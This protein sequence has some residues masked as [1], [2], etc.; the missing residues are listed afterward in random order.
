M[1]KYL[2]NTAELTAVADAIRTKGGTEELLTYPAGFVT[3]IEN[4]STGSN[5]DLPFAN[6][7]GTLEPINSL[8][9]VISTVESMF[10]FSGQLGG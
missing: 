4:I 8:N 1:A 3:A 2:T 6:F 7:A 9:N 5:S 10:T